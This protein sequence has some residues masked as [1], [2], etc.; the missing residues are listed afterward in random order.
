VSVDCQKQ[1]DHTIGVDSRIDGLITAYPTNPTLPGLK[2]QAAQN[3]TDAK[4]AC[5]SGDLAKAT[6]L[7]ASSDSLESQAKDAVATGQGAATSGGGG[8]A[9]GGTFVP[10]PNCDS[11]NNQVASFS[12]SLSTVAS[13]HSTS[14]GIAAQKAIGDKAAADATSKCAAG[15]LA[16]ANTALKLLFDAKNTAQ[17]ISNG[18]LPDAAPTGVTPSPAAGTPTTTNTSTFSKTAMFAVGGAAVGAGIGALTAKGSAKG[19]SAAIGTGAGILAGLIAS[20][21]MKSKDQA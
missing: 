11:V 8:G 16:G 17:S 10:A 9:A 20:M 21:A 6:S 7:A 1:I 12:L 13:M 4:A 2:T 19:V 14:P 18:T 3:V 15:D 5:A